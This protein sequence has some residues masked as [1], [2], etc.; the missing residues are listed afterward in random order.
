MAKAE[1]KLADRTAESNKQLQLREKAV[2]D[3]E[4][5][6]TDLRNRVATFPKELDASIAKAVKESTDRVTSVC[7]HHSAFFSRHEIDLSVNFNLPPLAALWSFA[8][9]AS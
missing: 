1:K 2:A 7:I 6:L 3:R 4:Q 5:E 9:G 8:P